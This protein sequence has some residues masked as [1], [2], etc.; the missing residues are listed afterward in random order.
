M[1][2]ERAMTATNSLAERIDAEFT[3]AADKIKRFQNEQIQEHHA[4]EQRLERLEQ[5]LDELREHWQPRVEAVVQ[6]FGDRIQVTPD[7]A[8]GRR[9]MTFQFQSELA[10]IRLRFS[11]TTN[12][13]VT[14]VVFTYDL[15]ILP[16]LMQFD[17]HD[18]IEFPLD[19]VDRKALVRWVDDRIVSAVRT[20]LSLNENELYL[21]KFM[22]EDPVAHVRFPKQAAGATLEWKGKT[23]YF[24]GEE[25]RRE[26]EQQQGI[27]A[28]SAPKN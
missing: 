1:K 23:Y 9:H 3:A 26:F 2:Q 24:V 13:D 25:T 15:E 28:D 18:E 11:A 10:Q 17:S 12:L 21:K 14:R 19:A 6:R 5:L 16:I 20:Y 7:V 4:R 22:V 27:A 8:R